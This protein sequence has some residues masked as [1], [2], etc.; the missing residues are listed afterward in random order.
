MLSISVFVTSKRV[1]VIAMAN[2]TSQMT[3]NTENSQL[4]TI[5]AQL[6]RNEHN[7]MNKTNLMFA[8]HASLV[9]K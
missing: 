7:L 1:I 9:R 2:I 3:Q 4:F 5:A 6:E 8:I